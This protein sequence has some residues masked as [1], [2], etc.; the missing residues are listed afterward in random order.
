MS[1]L[2]LA[3]AVPWFVYQYFRVGTALLEVMFGEHVMQ[4]FTTSLDPMH[5]KPWNYYYT[6]IYD[7]LS[8]IGLAWLATAGAILLIV[9]AVVKPTLAD[10]LVI[11]W[12][13][14]PLILISGGTSKL[15]HYAYPFLPPVALAVGFGPAWV[16]DV[17]RPHLVAIMQ[18]LERGVGALSDRL[19][20]V[21]PILLILSIAAGIVS[22]AT[23][24][25][26][27]VDLRLGGV[28]ILRN[29]HIVR[30]LLLSFVL[31]AV[32]G[33]A[34]TA[35]RLL[36]PAA[37]LMAI[38]PIHE[39]GNSLTGIAETKHLLRDTGACLLR[40]REG[41]RA[42]GHRAP[43]IYAVGG[44][45]WFLHSYYYY[46]RQAGA[47]ESTPAG[48]A[49]TIAKGLFAAG[50]QRPILIGDDGY[51]AVKQKWPEVGQVVPSLA[52]RDVL[53]LLPGPYAVCAPRG[54]L[55]ASD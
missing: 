48:D 43:G 33:R 53:L 30:P 14:V 25:L 41:E 18:A 46:F 16:L 39:Y 21:R 13:A 38:V 45:R 17:A 3:L 12:F 42:A 2:F 5:V 27:Q 11:A 10:W 51:R 29:S 35:S 15:H 19:G 31:A 44:A 20:P 8:R 40:V 37:L 50:E 32:A 52:L 34:V 7:T 26:G 54:G 49:E 55:A 9:R 6:T 4:R 28:Q 36:V 24:V 23:F 22:V 1:A 47:W